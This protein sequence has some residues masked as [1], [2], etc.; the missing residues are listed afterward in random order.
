MHLRR[1]CNSPEK[2]QRGAKTDDAKCGHA[3]WR[4]PTKMAALQNRRV[5]QPDPKS[6]PDLHA[7]QW[8][9]GK[10][11]THDSQRV[12]RKP[13]PKQTGDG[14]EQISQRGQM[15]KNRMQV[16]CFELA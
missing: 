14:S 11:T 6:G 9:A 8:M 13:P 15:I 4:E 7:R 3:F 2:R 1:E 5:K 10:K 12:K 16:M